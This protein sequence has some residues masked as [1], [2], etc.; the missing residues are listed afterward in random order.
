[1]LTSLLV[2]V[3]LAGIGCT[4][5]R[6]SSPGKIELAT[7]TFDFGTIT[8][9]DSVS[10]T[11][12]V[13]NVGQGPLEILGV[14]T[15]CACTTVEVDSRRLGPGD[16]THLRVTYDPQAHDGVTGKFMRVVY[17][18]SDDPVTPEAALTIWVTVVEPAEGEEG[19]STASGVNPNAIP[20]DRGVTST[21]GSVA[22]ERGLTTNG[23][24]VPWCPQE[25]RRER[26]VRGGGGQEVKR[27]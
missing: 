15:S 7:D 11:V 13:R 21:S 14:S 6:L 27:A 25:A 26:R 10:Q 3:L 1:M 23:P 9:T 12:Q 4:R 24:Q 18:R 19:G 17:V 16:A 20:M 22:G 5:D 2:L 8:N